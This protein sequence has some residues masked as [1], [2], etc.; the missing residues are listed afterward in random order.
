M[1]RLLNHL[2][3]AVLHLG[4]AVASL[5]CGRAHAEDAVLL[6]STVPG[7]NPGMVVA[8]ADRL[9]VPEG[10]TA[11]LLFQS[12][13][14]LRL[15]GPFD[16]T[17]AQQRPSGGSGSAAMFADMFRLHGVDA[18]VIGGT[19]SINPGRPVAA[20]DD[21]QV[22]PERSGTYCVEPA[23]SVWITRPSGG[24]GTY[25]LRRKGNNRA[26]AWPQGAQRIEWPADVPIEDG[27]QFEITTG[28]TARATVTFRDVAS[29]TGGAARIARGFVLGCRDQF[30]EEL[31]R[32][33]RLVVG[34]EVWIT[35]DRGR[36]PTYHAGEPIALTVTANMDG[37]LYC[38]AGADGGARP[39]FPAGAFNGAQ[40]PG[41]VPLPIPGRRQ[42]V[43]LTASPAVGQVRCWLADRDISPELPHAL[44]G[45]PSAPLPDQMAGELDALFSH[46]GGTRIETDVLTIRTE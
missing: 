10:A 7:Y 4:L 15:R 26:L 29:T 20:L 9:S 6:A 21:V 19:R 22:D 46:I 1:P 16:G 41:S 40:L 12:G 25:A 31:K 3:R 34:P 39:L 13:E 23:T 14:V 45:A 33:S 8:T 18:T 2:G 11:T 43:G 5:A 32:F 44:L 42:P 24:P 27:S 17:L 37:Y 38:V 36:R 28:G 30:E 35:T